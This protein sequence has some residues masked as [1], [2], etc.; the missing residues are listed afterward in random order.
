MN[1]AGFGDTKLSSFPRYDEQVVYVISGH[2][3]TCNPRLTILSD[4]GTNF[5]WGK[6]TAVASAP[7]CLHR[8]LVSNLGISSRIT[9]SLTGQTSENEGGGFE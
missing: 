7:V 3:I 4:A 6:G 5:N 2:L 1:Q 9:V 8:C